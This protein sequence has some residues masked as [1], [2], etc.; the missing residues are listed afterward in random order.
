MKK[1]L[2]ALLIL[3]AIFLIVP[4]A[5]AQT[6]SIDFSACRTIKSQGLTGIANCAIGFFNAAVYFL[7]TLAV[8]FTVLGAFQMIASE[9]KRESGKQRVI[10]GII[11][12]FVMVSIWGF[13]NILERTFGTG[14]EQARPAPKLQ[15]FQP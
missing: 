1:A 10:Y 12:L 13:V 9:E 2:F 14:G 5:H 7:M 6:G 15:F 4:D 11:G 8:I 3:S